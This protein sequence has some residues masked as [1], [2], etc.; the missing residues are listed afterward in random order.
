MNQVKTGKISYKL[1]CKIFVCMCVSVRKNAPWCMWSSEDFFFFYTFLNSRKINYFKVLVFFLL[2]IT[3]ISTYVVIITIF[4]L[5]WHGM[6][7]LSIYVQ[8]AFQD[9]ESN[10]WVP[11]TYTGVMQQFLCACTYICS[12]G[13]L[14]TFTICR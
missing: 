13:M 11:A 3:S 9:L 2:V 14:S 10:W 12:G 4:D 7:S 5:T 1:T 6:N 8:W